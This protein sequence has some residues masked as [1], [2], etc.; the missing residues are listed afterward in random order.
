MPRLSDDTLSGLLFIA[1]A[2]FFGVT[3][4]GRLKSATSG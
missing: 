1:L 2:V 3:A 4:P